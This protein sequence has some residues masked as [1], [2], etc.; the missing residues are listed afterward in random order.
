MTLSRMLLVLTISLS[1]PT[2][3]LLAA[4]TKQFN[5]TGYTVTW[6]PPST[7]ANRQ[8]GYITLYSGTRGVAYIN[9]VT[10]FT[11]LGQYNAG[12]DYFVFNMMTYEY[13]HIIDVVRNEG[14]STI[15]GSWNDQNQLTQVVMHSRRGNFTSND[16][17]HTLANR[18]RSH[19]QAGDR[20]KPQQ[21]LPSA[22]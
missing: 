3:D 22:P 18:V 15:H 19:A 17:T 2:T 7:A 4:G 12:S 16:P 21:L 5:V 9:F 20:R 14:I 13:E 1:F 11:S 10:N 6:V 8:F